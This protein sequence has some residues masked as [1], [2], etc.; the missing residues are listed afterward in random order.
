MGPSRCSP[1]FSSLAQTSPVCSPHSDI[2]SSAAS[3]GAWVPK[4][5]RIRR[6]PTSQ[7][8]WRSLSQLQQ[9][10]GTSDCAPPPWEQCFMASPAP[11][12]QREVSAVK[13]PASTSGPSLV[14]EWTRDTNNPTVHPSIHSSIHI[15]MYACMYVS[16][17]HPSICP[18]ICLTTTFTPIT[19]RGLVKVAYLI[20]MSSS[21]TTALCMTAVGCFSVHDTRMFSRPNLVLQVWLTPRELSAISPHWKAKKLC[22]DV[23]EGC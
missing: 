5:M 14:A 4:S 2:N 19:K 21:T 3:S 9:S 15:C 8:P 17:I 1:L 13:T 11:W 16:S 6:P 10:L 20:E 7:Q 12:Y 18:H 23:R 22:S